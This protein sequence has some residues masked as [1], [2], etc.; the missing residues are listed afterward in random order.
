MMAAWAAAVLIFAAAYGSVFNDLDSFVADNSLY[1]AM[2]G[3]GADKSDIMNPRHRHD[4]AHHD[5]YGSDSRGGRS[6]QAQR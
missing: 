4:D 2:L 3:V 6:A 1:Q 5:D